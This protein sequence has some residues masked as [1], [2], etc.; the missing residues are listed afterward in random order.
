MESI[1]CSLCKGFKLTDLSGVTKLSPKTNKSV[2]FNDN[3]NSLKG[4]V[5]LITFIDHIEFLCV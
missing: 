4:Y 2:H 1:H 5:I 3:R